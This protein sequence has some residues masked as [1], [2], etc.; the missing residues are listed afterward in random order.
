MGVN[1][2]LDSNQEAHISL[3][4]DQSSTPTKGKSSNKRKTPHDGFDKQFFDIMSSFSSMVDLP[5][6]EIVTRLD[7]GMNML[8]IQ[9]KL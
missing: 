4:N 7:T 1:E 2:K 3:S 5:L 6:G 9:G 8:S